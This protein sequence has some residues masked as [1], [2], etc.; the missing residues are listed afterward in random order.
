[1]L[2]RSL[3]T[4]DILQLGSSRDGEIQRET[5]RDV[6]TNCDPSSGG[7]HVHNKAIIFMVTI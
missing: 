4:R 6:E 2:S 7:C 1:M 5:L 3:A